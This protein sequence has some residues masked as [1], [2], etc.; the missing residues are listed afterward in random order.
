RVACRGRRAV[1]WAVPSGSDAGR[2]GR[3]ARRLVDCVRGRGSASPGAYPGRPQRGGIAP[4][5]PARH[6][7]R[8]GGTGLVTGDRARSAAW[9]RGTSARLSNL[10]RGAERDGVLRIRARSAALAG[11]A[12]GT[13]SSDSGPGTQ[14]RVGG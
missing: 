10:R 12:F 11:A 7:D 5:L 3:P 6:S 4:A 1:A 9:G 13:R 2:A 8:A 14:W